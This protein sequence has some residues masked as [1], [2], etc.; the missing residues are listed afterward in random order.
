[1]NKPIHWSP[2]DQQKLTELIERKK[3]FDEEMLKPIDDLLA[4]TLVFLPA[5]VSSGST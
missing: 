3:A 1:M 4:R 2:A 5:G